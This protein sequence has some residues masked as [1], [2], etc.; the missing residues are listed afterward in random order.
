MALLLQP[1]CL[2]AAPRRS[3]ATAAGGLWPVAHRARN[4]AAYGERRSANRSNW[5]TTE[6]PVG[7]PA[8]AEAEPTAEE[9]PIAEQIWRVAQDLA[10]V[11]A[12]ADRLIASNSRK[13]QAAFRRHR[14][15]PHHFQGSTGYGHGDLG[16]EALDS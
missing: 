14:I 2:A 1:R 4:V 10:P 7:A 6:V 15:G 11:F 12:A 5:A 3:P 9:L 8:I 13:V 16:R